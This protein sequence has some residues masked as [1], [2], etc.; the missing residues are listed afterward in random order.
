MSLTD[1]V[2]AK[3]STPSLATLAESASPR[4][5]TLQ[6]PSPVSSPVREMNPSTPLILELLANYDD[7]SNSPRSSP[8]PRTPNV[9]GS[10]HLPSP[11]VPPNATPHRQE[12][13]AQEIRL[14]AN[15]SH[16][17]SQSPNDPTWHSSPVP[18]SNT[19]LMA[20]RPSQPS[21]TTGANC[22]YV[23]TKRTGFIIPER[24]NPRQEIKIHRKK[25]FVEI[26]ARCN[27]LLATGCAENTQVDI[28]VTRINAYKK[29]PLRTPEGPF[30]TPT[31]FLSQEP[32]RTYTDSHDHVH[33]E[34]TTGRDGNIMLNFRHSSVHYSLLPGPSTTPEASRVWELTV[35]PLQGTCLTE[36]RVRL[37]VLSK[38]RHSTASP[39][40]PKQGRPRKGG[41]PGV[42]TSQLLL[43]FRQLPAAYQIHHLSL[44]DITLQT[45]KG[46]AILG[47]ID[48]ASKT[49]PI[50]IQNDRSVL[51][52]NSRPEDDAD[53]K[54]SEEIPLHAE[55]EE[56]LQETSSSSKA[57]HSMM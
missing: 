50:Q 7:A 5:S 26:K 48:P 8:V 53:T 32:I 45:L 23:E 41:P 9:A 3:A 17:G 38:L 49:I 52:S 31:F 18:R 25:D 6:T 1:S 35:R 36:T 14:N 27:V 21:T 34:T 20:P 44:I 43:K 11:T 19:P 30:N 55:I 13:R 46:T 28:L 56:F 15:P 47:E 29:F 57:Q 37:K 51:T 40:K 22:T 4:S 42:S 10:V 54:S 16:A 33:V 2:V 39:L 12:I 24:L